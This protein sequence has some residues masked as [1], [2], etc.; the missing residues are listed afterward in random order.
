M[1]THNLKESLIVIEIIG[2]FLNRYEF[3]VLQMFVKR[4]LTGQPLA[5]V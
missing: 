4:L 5:N 3:L 1:S 2:H